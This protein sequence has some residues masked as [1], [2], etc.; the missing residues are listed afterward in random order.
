MVLND[1][2]GSTFVLGKSLADCIVLDDFLPLSCSNFLDDALC[3]KCV[4]LRYIYDFDWLYTLF[5][6]EENLG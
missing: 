2:F 5:G 4:F 1:Q 3:L 6:C